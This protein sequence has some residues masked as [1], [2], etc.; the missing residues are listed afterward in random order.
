MDRIK[1]IRTLSASTIWHL[2][3]VDVNDLEVVV[4]VVVPLHMLLANR[5]DVGDGAGGEPLSLQVP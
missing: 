1:A 5:F 2:L 4:E 3:L